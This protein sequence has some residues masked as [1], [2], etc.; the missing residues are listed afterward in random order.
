MEVTANAPSF[1]T[2]KELLL[3]QYSESANLGKLLSA[4]S[5]QLDSAEAAAL[6]IKM[7]HGVNES[8][9]DQ[10]DLI[11]E[12]FA[13]ERSSRTDV[14][15]RIA[16]HIRQSL[17]GQGTVEDMIRAYKATFGSTWVKYILTPYGVLFDTDIGGHYPGVYPFTPAGVN[18][19]TMFDLASYEALPR[20]IV[21]ANGNHIIGLY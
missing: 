10:L 6:Q 9:G 21:D 8:S 5:T 20:K 13:T 14:E 19:R 1:E 18:V 11:G 4:F 3:T 12:M 2:L 16:I 15:Y 17:Q 7:I